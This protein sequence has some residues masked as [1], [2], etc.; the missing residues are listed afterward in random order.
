MNAIKKILPILLLIFTA[1]FIV[2]FN[3]FVFGQSSGI[4]I[5]FQ[6]IEVRDGA[7][8]YKKQLANGNAAYLQIIDVGKMQ[9]DQIIGEVDKMGIG[10]G[11]YYQGENQYYSPFF[12]MRLFSEVAEEYKKL[13]DASVF[14]AINC[15]FFEQYQSSTQLSFPVKI[16]GQVVTAGNSPYGPIKQPKN[17]FYQNVRLKALVWNER[18]VYITDYHPE[19]GKPLSDSEVQN[20]VVTYLYSDHPAKVLANN[21][22]NRY[23]VIGTLNKDDTNGDESLAIITVNRST[24]DEAANLLRDLGVK[25]DIITIDGG[26]STYIFNFKLGNIMLP[27]SSGS[28]SAKLPHYLGFRNRNTKPD[29]PHILV[30]QPIGKVQVEANKPYLILWRDNLE[31]DVKIELYEGNKLIQTIRDRTAS[32]G[33]Y[34]W[35]PKNAIKTGDLI[36]IS[37][38]ENPQVFGV[39]QL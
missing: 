16:N 4:D 10:Q 22:I 5:S 35:T 11:A 34:E 2:K 3:R 6:P 15:S 12:K 29:S 36:R 7:G 28:V 21:P 24:L 37:S 32:D 1:I 39:L 8:L 25:G 33:V 13:Y 17:E 20:A 9:I 26:T 27:Q 38:V 31:G 30:S 23:H 18:E 14:S 19:T